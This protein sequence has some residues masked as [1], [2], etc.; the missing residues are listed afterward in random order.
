MIASEILA[1]AAMLR[2]LHSSAFPFFGVERRGAPVTS[3]CR[4]DERPIRVHSGIYEPDQVVVLDQALFRQHDTLSGL[5]EHGKILANTTKTE[6]Q[7]GISPKFRLIPVDA[8]SIALK[9]R[10]GPST[11]PIVNTAM[12]G[13]LVRT[14]PGISID[15]M[16]ECIKDTVPVK[17]EEN[18]AAANDAYDT[19]RLI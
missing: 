9:R 12:L 2:G 16:I 1:K 15:E 5:K 8:T 7:L 18:A 11:A 10:L 13:V 4:I 14:L 17:K 6:A 19:W 3:F